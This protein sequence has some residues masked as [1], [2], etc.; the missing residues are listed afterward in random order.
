[1]LGKVT[2]ATVERL[3]AENAPGTPAINT[4]RTEASAFAPSSA[5]VIASYMASVSA[6]FLSGRFIRMV[7]MPSA[8]VT[9]TCSVTVYPIPSTSTAT[10]V[11]ITVVVRPGAAPGLRSSRSP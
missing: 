2:K 11:S 7:R 4:Q 1:M 8:S 9:I 3:L 10:G 6:F 5:A